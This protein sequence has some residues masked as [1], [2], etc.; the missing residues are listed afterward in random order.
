MDAN[1]VM[2]Q[3]RDSASAS[4]D[5]ARLEGKRLVVVS[6][7]EKGNRVQESF[8]K[9]ASGNDSLVA[10][11]LYQSEREF[12]PTHQFWFQTNYRPGFD[13]TDS[14]NKRRYI[15]IPFDNDLAADPLVNFDSK[16]KIRM[17]QDTEFLKAVLAWA[18]AGAVDWYKHGLQIPESVKAA[19][20]ALFA[21][22]DFINDFMNEMCIVDSHEQVSV[23][24]LWDAYKQEC[25]DQGEDPAKGRTFNRMLE[26][27]GFVRKQARIHGLSMK[28]WHGIRLKEDD[29]LVQDREKHHDGQ[30]GSTGGE[31]ENKTEVEQVSRLAPYVSAY[32]GVN[33]A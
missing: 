22:N 16:L 5:I 33:A 9:Q 15:E 17:C 7:I 4:G 26:E 25:Q 8:L 1:S 28:A 29:E 6:E 11:G 13:S 14:G 24:D 30:T 32:G 19:T 18:V 31:T 10:R 12:R 2:K 3:K 27:R 21:H 23:K 20:A